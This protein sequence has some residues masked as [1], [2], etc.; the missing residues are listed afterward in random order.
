MSFKFIHGVKKIKLFIA[1][2]FTSYIF[3]IF[4][5]IC[6]SDPIPAQNFWLKAYGGYDYAFFGDLITSSKNIP[7]MT[8]LQGEFLRPLPMQEIVGFRQVLSL[9][10]L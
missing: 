10:L 5:S 2:A 1:V 4:V 9:E 6:K 7:I 3:F 8:R